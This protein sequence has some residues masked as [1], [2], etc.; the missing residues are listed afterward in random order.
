[1]GKKEKKKQQGSNKPNIASGDIVRINS[2]TDT[3]DAK[4][5]IIDGQHGA[6]SYGDENK[7]KIPSRDREK[8]LEAVLKPGRIKVDKQGYGTVKFDDGSTSKYRIIDI[9]E[10]MVDI[11]DEHINRYYLTTSSYLTTHRGVD[12]VSNS[13]NTGTDEEKT[14]ID[15]MVTSL[16]DDHNDDVEED[17]ERR[18]IGLCALFETLTENDFNAAIYMWEQI[19][20]ICELA[21]PTRA[22]I[23]HITTAEKIAVDFSNTVDDTLK[24]DKR[25]FRYVYNLITRDASNGVELIN[26]K[27]NTKPYTDDEAARLLVDIYS[28]EDIKEFMRAYG[29]Y[30]VDRKGLMRLLISQKVFTEEELRTLINPASAFMCYADSG[31]KELLKYLGVNELV[32]LYHM[33]KIDVSQVARYSSIDQLLMSTISKESKMEIL[34]SGNGERVYGKTDTAV[35]WEL[36]EKNYFTHDDIKELESVRYLHVDTIIKN[37]YKDKKRKIAAEL[38]VI[39]EVTDEKI[40]EFFTPDIVLRELRSGINEEQKEF[41]NKDLRALY[42]AA[43]RNIEQELVNLIMA[44]KEEDSIKEYLECMKYYNEGIFSIDILKQINVPENIVLNDYVN[45]KSERKLIDFFNAELISQDTVIDVLD[46]DFDE[47]SFELI[48]NRM[49]ARII[50][51]FYSTSE[52]IAFTSDVNYAGIPVEPKLTIKQLAEIKEDIDTGLNG[53]SSA[54]KGKKTTTLLDLYLDGTIHYAELYDLANKGV[55]SKEEADEI[56]DHFNLDQG[57]AALERIGVSG[58][59]LANIFRPVPPPG[60][61]PKPKPSPKSKRSA[62]GIPTQYI[63][64]FYKEMGAKN[65]IQINGDDCPVFDGYVIIPI[66]DK[67]IGFLEGDDGRTYILPLKIILEQINNPKGQMD[68]IGNATSRNAFNRFKQFVRST[69]HTKNWMENTVKKAAEISPVMTRSDVNAFLTQ[70]AGLISLARQTYYVRKAHRI[71]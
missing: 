68:L 28:K 65:V 69:N 54:Q 18:E 24:R 32:G 25:S 44:N 16:Y 48:K 2:G 56:N 10:M 64:D 27:Y 71:I 19:K 33:G 17:A 36:Y 39:P 29:A 40:L 63:I 11:A 47:K 31:N 14:G 8:V 55:I 3:I 46:E 38:D 15:K 22:V 35:F 30:I 4:R 20:R 58:Q 66:V 7:N 59:P 51:G 1:M 21:E 70:N 67:K 41:Y 49:S 62:I 23:Q 61:T 42:E 37:Y 13:V 60:P 9:I 43:G 5:I 6:R 26:I 34:M 57:V 52:L 53:G 12:I 50:K 45:D